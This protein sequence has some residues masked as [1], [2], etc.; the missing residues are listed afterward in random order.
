[1]LQTQY[2]YEQCYIKRKFASRIHQELTCNSVQEFAF[3]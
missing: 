3:S 1:M 2:E